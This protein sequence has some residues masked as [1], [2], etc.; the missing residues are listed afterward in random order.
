MTALPP[1]VTRPHRWHRVLVLAALLVGLVTMHTLGHP[2]DSRPTAGPSAVRGV[3]H[4]VPSVGE[5]DTTAAGS[6][7]TGSGARARAGADVHTGTDAPGPEHV[8]SPPAPPDFGPSPTGQSDP[9]ARHPAERAPGTPHDAA[10][11]AHSAPVAAGL[12]GD[13]ALSGLLPGGDDRAGHGSGHGAGGAGSGLD[14]MSVCLAVL[15]GLI[16]L[17][18]GPSRH[19]LRAADAADPTAGAPRAAH[20]SPGP[21]P[22]AG[23]DLLDRQVVLRV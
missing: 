5:A 9:P 1:R 16:P 13:G 3:A 2:E 19:G 23:R 17:L 6:G 7:G 14:P 22:P 12:L 20:P 10:P 11:L 8:A 15:A 18:L 4:A 21:A